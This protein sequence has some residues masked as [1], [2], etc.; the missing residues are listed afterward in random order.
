MPDPIY[1]IDSLENFALDYLYKTKE[2][3]WVRLKNG[4]F[5]YIGHSNIGV[6]HAMVDSYIEEH[7]LPITMVD[8]VL[9]SEQR[10]GH[11]IDAI[12]ADLS[13]QGLISIDEKGNIL[14]LLAKL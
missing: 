13:N 4:M 9:I 10:M 3:H 12:I 6:V 2:C 7:N 5:K 8:D 14:S 11:V 1:N